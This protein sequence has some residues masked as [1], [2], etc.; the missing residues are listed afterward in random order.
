MPGFGKPALPGVPLAWSLM[1]VPSKQKR[2]GIA[3]PSG[4]RKPL[5]GAEFEAEAGGGRIGRHAG[6]QKN[7]SGI[8]A[9]AARQVSNAPAV[10]Q[11]AFSGVSGVDWRGIANAF[12]GLA[13]VT[14]RKLKVHNRYPRHGQ[15]D[16]GARHGL[17]SRLACRDAVVTR[18]QRRHRVAP[19]EIR[20]SRPHHAGLFI[21]RAH[22]C[23]RNNRP[24]LVSDRA[25]DA[26]R[27]PLRIAL[28]SAEEKTR[29]HKKAEFPGHDTFRFRRINYFLAGGLAL[30]RNRL[31]FSGP[32]T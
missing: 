5:P 13:A 28:R 23:P 27:R 9:G 32:L 25:P 14:L 1:S 6:L 3:A 18:S 30:S 22:R 29:C 20:H 17:K 11:R 2:V 15:Y 31:L 19:G 10:Q 8:V 7:E 4:G 24:L 26:A 16:S 21:D 12:H